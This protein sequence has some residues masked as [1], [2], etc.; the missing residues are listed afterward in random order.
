MQSNSAVYSIANW[1]V[2]QV[3]PSLITLRRACRQPSP[4]LAANTR[5]RTTQLVR[6]GHVL[7][8]VDDDQVARG[9]A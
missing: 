3:S 9:A 7:G 8:V 2:S 5:G 6:L 1:R 4:G